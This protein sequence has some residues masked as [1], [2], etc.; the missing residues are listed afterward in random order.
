M[1]CPKGTY[2][3]NINK[4]SACTAC[5]DG[6]TTT[7]TKSTTSSACNTAMPGFRP[8]IVNG[9]VTGSDPCPLN[10]Y[11]TAG[12]SCTTCPDGLQTQT[13]GSSTAGDCTA[14]P[15]Y[16]Y[17]ANGVGDGYPVTTATLNGAKIIQC[18][19]G[20]YKVGLL[21]VVLGQRLA[22]ASKPATSTLIWRVLP[23]AN[24]RARL[25]LCHIRGAAAADGARTWPL[26][27]NRYVRHASMSVL[28]LLLL[29]LQAGWQ[30]SPCV[31]CGISIS[32]N[33]TYTDGLGISS[34]Q[35]F[36]PAGWGST[37]VGTTKQLVA[38]P[39]KAGTFGTGDVIMGIV[40]HPCQVR[41]L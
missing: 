37:L 40:P 32:T 26:L 10:T 29:L 4:A 27:Q 18:P 33:V 35:C 8:V 16:G 17:Y 24:G 9:V 1:P 34:D 3:V 2:Q 14:G 7:S 6:V 25:R 11:S 19:L 15:G 30:K 23:L 13:T 31:S 38:K 39:C 5:P 36:I 41:F 12:T 21:L 20:S 22:A 28:L